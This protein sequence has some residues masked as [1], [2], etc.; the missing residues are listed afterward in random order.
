MT[1]RRTRDGKRKIVSTGSQTFTVKL[2]PA[3]IEYLDW[4]QQ[5][6]QEKAERRDGDVTKDDA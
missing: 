1:S 3:E 5:K 2:T 6:R 4:L